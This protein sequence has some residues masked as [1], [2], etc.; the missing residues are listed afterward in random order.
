MHRTI[1]KQ[2]VAAL[3][4]AVGLSA[5]AAGRSVIDVMPPTGMVT[6]GAGVAKIVEVR[7][8]R[9]F[10]AAPK[11]PSTP[12]LR[13]A[14]DIS[15][16]MITAR[17]LAR[18]RGGYGNALGDIVLPEG[19]SVAGLVKGAMQK[20]LQDKGYR[21]VEEGSPDYARAV[22]VSV[23]IQSFWAWFTPGFAAITVECKSAVRLTGGA[24]TTA[25]PPPVEGYAMASGIG[26]FES[27]WADVIKRA[28]DDLSGKMEAQIKSP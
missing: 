18:K 4:L 15:N 21:V 26:A 12:S 16:P 5:C 9:V 23:E 22:P 10:E 25:S 11:D 3:V 6:N 13:S 1:F 8:R 20:A 14:A 24:F 19:R 28:L 17:A 7:D 27:T 2:L